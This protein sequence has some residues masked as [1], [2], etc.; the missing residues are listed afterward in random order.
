M[1]WP[2]GK[3]VD[4]ANPTKSRVMEMSTRSTRAQSAPPRPPPHRISAQRHLINRHSDR[5]F[6]RNSLRSPMS[7]RWRVR[8]PDEI[9][10]V[11]ETHTLGTKTSYQPTCRQDFRSKFPLGGRWRVCI[12]DEVEGDGDE[13]EVDE[14]GRNNAKGY[15]RGNYPLNVY[16]FG[17]FSTKEQRVGREALLYC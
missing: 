13:H 16:K 9:E 15:R 7:G 17:G 1:F 3:W 5:M 8:I 11:M 6:G 10:R 2:R 4:S 14:R 12:P